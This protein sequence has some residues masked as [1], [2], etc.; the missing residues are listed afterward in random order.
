MFIKLVKG[1]SSI[2]TVLTVKLI[3]LATSLKQIVGVQ[4]DRWKTAQDA[5]KI[6][7]DLKANLKKQVNDAEAETKKE[8]LY[9]W[10]WT[11]VA[12]V[13]GVKVVTMR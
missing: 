6:D 13:L 4:E 11:G 5:W 10:I 8:K 1:K 12:A 9:R 2:P 7:Q 3:I